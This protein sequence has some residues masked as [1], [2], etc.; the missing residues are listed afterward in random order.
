MEDSL[1]KKMVRALSMLLVLVSVSTFSVM[2]NGQTEGVTEGDAYP[3]KQ[4][5]VTC[6]PAAGGGTDLLYRALAPKIS[7]KLGVPVII[8]NKP[9]AGGAIGFSAGAKEKADG[10]SVTAAVAE[11]LAVPYV[12]NVDFTYESFEPVCNVNSTYGTLTVQADAPY[13]TVEEFIDYCKAHPGEV[14]FSNSGNGGNWHVLAAAFAAA[15]G[16]DVVHVP[17]DGGG[18]SAIALAGGHVEATTV[19]AQEVEVHV[20]S[21]KAKILCSFSPERLAELP[22]IPTLRELGYGDLLL[23]IY[24][25]FVAPK[26]TPADV[27]AKIDEAIQYALN[28]P[29]ITE[30]MKNKNFMK[31]YKDADDFLALME[32]ENKIYGEQF[33]ALGMID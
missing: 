14:R 11:M 15:A 28:D 4:L 21:G 16:I 31:D 25:G 7:E 33:K 2:A 27:I 29:E 23:T 22:E 6:P 12:Q 20:A 17:F 30:F 9:G 19:S 18:P 13:D 24:R 5:I 3:A 10:S 1:M 32:R 8:V 26:G